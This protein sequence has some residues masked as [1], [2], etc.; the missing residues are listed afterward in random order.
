MTPAA[1]LLLVAALVPVQMACAQADGCTVAA[2]DLALGRYD[3]L[4]TLP[5]DA[6]QYDAHSTVS[7]V[8]PGLWF[9]RLRTPRT[10]WTSLRTS[11]RHRS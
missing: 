6:R 5:Q 7:S 9:G 10:F 3:P 2:Q 8:P 11:S 4:N 1:V